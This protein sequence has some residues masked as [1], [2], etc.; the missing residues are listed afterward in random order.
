MGKMVVVPARGRRGHPPR[1]PRPVKS[2]VR[3]SIF[4]ANEQKMRDYDLS[5]VF[6]TLP[7]TWVEQD[8]STVGEGDA[9]YQR[10]GREIRITSLEIKCTFHVVDNPG[11]TFRV[12]IG[13]FN[14]TQATP[15]ATAG[16]SYDNILVP[17]ACRNFLM[18]KYFDKYICINTA[19][20]TDRYFHYFKKFKKPIVIKF[21]DDTST[22]PD[23]R[24]FV[25]I[26]SDSG[27][28]THPYVAAGYSLTRFQ[29]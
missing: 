20:E 9:L 14:G 18:K 24:L 27:A 7:N 25:S 12:V 28:V 2:Y 21:G 3:R 10:E 6:A 1:V 29:G 8:V 13:L 16:V 22:Y 5:T 19:S 15:L 17:V 11:N 23:K 4:R 26:M